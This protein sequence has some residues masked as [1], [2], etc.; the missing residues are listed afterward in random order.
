MS[1]YF[2]Q[3]NIFYKSNPNSRFW[4]E[5]FLLLFCFFVSFLEGLILGWIFWCKLLRISFYASFF[6]HWNPV[7]ALF[8]PVFA[9]FNPVLNFHNP[10]PNVGILP[11]DCSVSVNVKSSV[12]SKNVSNKKNQ[13]FWDFGSQ[14]SYGIKV[15]KTNHGL[16]HFTTYFRLAF[17]IRKNLFY[18]TKL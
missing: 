2:V 3:S 5:N 10:D 4:I 16:K 12:L 13:A 9:L 11:F 14:F 6:A 1:N 7:F 8:N 15:K 18:I 17:V